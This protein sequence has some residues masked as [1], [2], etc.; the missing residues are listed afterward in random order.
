MGNEVRILK[1]GKISFSLEQDL[2]NVVAM[3]IRAALYYDKDDFP[4]YLY[5][6]LEEVVTKLDRPEERLQ[7]RRSEFFAV[8]DQVVMQ[9]IDE[10]T[11][12]ILRAML[13]WRPAHETMAGILLVDEG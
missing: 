8:F 3:A 5:Y 6:L 7:L 11:Q 9:Y 2:R 4:T 1:N 12:H 10:P 13:S